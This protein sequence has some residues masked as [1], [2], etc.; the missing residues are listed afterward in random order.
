MYKGFLS[1]ERN[2]WVVKLNATRDE[3]EVLVR[4][5]SPMATQDARTFGLYLGT[6]F[7]GRPVTGPAILSRQELSEAEVLEF[8]ADKVRIDIKSRLMTI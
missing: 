2:F 4:F 5:L 7:Q 3:E 8:F 6:D 1:F